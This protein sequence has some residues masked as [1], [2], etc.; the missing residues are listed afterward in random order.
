MDVTEWRANREFR[1]EGIAE[2]RMGLCK[3]KQA[4]ILCKIDILD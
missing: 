3:R 1:P 4:I 2:L